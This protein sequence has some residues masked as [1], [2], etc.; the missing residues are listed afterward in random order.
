MSTYSSAVV[1]L[2]LGRSVTVETVIC[3]NGC[4]ERAAQYVAAHPVQDGVY[5]IQEVE[6]EVI[7]RPATWG[8]VGER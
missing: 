4:E 7:E 3:G 6:A 5:E 1:L 8:L 2:H